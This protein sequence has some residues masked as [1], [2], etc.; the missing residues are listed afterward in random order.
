MTP[1]QLLSKP[2]ERKHGRPPVNP[3]TSRFW[4]T[5]LHELLASRLAH[6]EGLVVDGRIVPA[7]LAQKVGRCRFTAYR[8]LGDNRISPGGAKK[9]IDISGGQLTK[10]ELA[11]FLIL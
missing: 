11:P 6:V 5:A 2:R 4:E 9:L 10:E 7:K 3:N 8:W 1:E